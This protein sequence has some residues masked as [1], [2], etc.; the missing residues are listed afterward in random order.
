MWFTG[1]YLCS[2]RYCN[3]FVENEAQSMMCGTQHNDA[4][5]PGFKRADSIKYAALLQ[6]KY[7]AKT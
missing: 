7:R 2:P 3:E 1:K 6:G 4:T 5:P